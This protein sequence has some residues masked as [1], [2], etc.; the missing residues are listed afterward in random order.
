MIMSLLKPVRSG[1][2]QFYDA[3]H[4]IL[5]SHGVMLGRVQF[6]PY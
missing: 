3:C 1:T 5:I 2:V 4:V 6:A